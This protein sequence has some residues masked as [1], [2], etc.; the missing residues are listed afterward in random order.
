[1]PWEVSSIS[2]STLT[3]VPGFTITEV[4]GLVHGVGNV[5]T[6][7]ANPSVAFTTA[8]KAERAMEKAEQQLRADAQLLGA[9]AVVGVLIGVDSSGGGLNRA[10]TLQLVGTAVRLVKRVS[11]PPSKGLAL[12][13]G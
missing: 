8:G 1:M 13:S 7:V 2:V 4:L 9:D 12:P 5:A 11:S 6:S 10:Q 3:E